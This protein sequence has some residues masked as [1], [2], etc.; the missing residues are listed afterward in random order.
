MQLELGR[1]YPGPREEEQIAAIASL[2]SQMQ[3]EE[4]A[5][6]KPM[7]RDAHGKH[8]GIVRAELTVEPNLPPELRAGLFKE[9]KTFACYIRFSNG[10]GTPK[11]DSVK[12][13][14]GMAIKVLG[15]PGEKLLEDEK[16][17][18]TQDF[19]LISHHSFFVK[20]LDDYVSLFEGFKHGRRMS[21]FLGWNPAKWKIR[22]LRNVLSTAITISDPL[23]T[24]Y[25]STVPFAYG[26]GRAAKFSA[27]PHKLANTG[28][29][30]GAGDDFLRAAM[31]KRLEQ[32]DVLFDF[33]VQLQVDPVAMPIEDATIPWSEKLSPYRKVATIRIPKQRFDSPA[34]M[35]LAENISFTPWHAVPD[36]KPLGAMNRCRKHVYWEISKLRHEHNGAPRREPDGSERFE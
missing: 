34:Q 16:D 1:E 29:P 21:H 13:G 23:T 35:E 22:E 26:P 6:K 11:P 14:R 33:L 3:R 17:E 20:N 12:D 4:Y 15:V 18:Q 2:I 25:W 30:A 28:V 27:R 10:E 7:R 36:L 19:L 31:K 32:E 24:R 8:H 5:G 9:M